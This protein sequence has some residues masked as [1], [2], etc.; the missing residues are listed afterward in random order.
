MKLAV[1]F[2]DHGVLQRE[3]PIPVWGWATPGER[4]TVRLAGNEAHATA[5]ADG[6]WRVTLPPLPAGGPHELTVAFYRR[7]SVS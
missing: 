4:V 7:H 1:V 3:L 5:D 2:S 6:A